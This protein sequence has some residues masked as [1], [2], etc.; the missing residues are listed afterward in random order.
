MKPRTE[1]DSASCL[2]SIYKITPREQ[3]LLLVHKP[4]QEHLSGVI[5]LDAA[6]GHDPTPTMKIIIIIMHL[7]EKHLHFPIHFYCTRF[8]FL[9]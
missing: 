6:V 1:L 3:V 8:V 7:S 5:Q 4:L 2:G 9:R